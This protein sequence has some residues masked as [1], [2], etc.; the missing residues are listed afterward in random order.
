MF[1]GLSNL[2]I[3]FGRRFYFP[4]LAFLDEGCL[5][6]WALWRSGLSCQAQSWYSNFGVL[7]LVSF[8]GLNF[9][10]C[11]PQKVAVFW[12]W[13]GLH[14]RQESYGY[15][16]QRV[17]V[18]GLNWPAFKAGELRLLPSESCGFLDWTEVPLGVLF[19]V[20]FQGVASAV[21][22]ISSSS[23]FFFTL[24]FI[25]QDCIRCKPYR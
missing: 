9:S 18:L 5:F 3:F 4:I 1:F 19:L 24:K 21:K 14:S 17:A 8:F 2:R 12:V 13:T 23:G 22:S 7:S 25:F 10:G 16:P 20:S 15:S 11:F 6:S